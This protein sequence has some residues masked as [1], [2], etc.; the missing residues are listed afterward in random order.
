MSAKMKNN[1][2]LDQNTLS[3]GI[4]FGSTRV[5]AVLI[6]DT[7]APIASGAYDWENKLVE[8]YWTYSLD[9]VWSGLQHAFSELSQNVKNDYDVILTN[10]G[11]IGFSGMMHGY[12]AF[13]KDE[14]LLVPFRTWRNTT[15]DVASKKLTELFEFNI[16]HRWSIAHLY[17]AVLNKEEHVQQIDYVTTLAGFVHWKLT[18]QK[19]IGVGEAA[20]MF[21]IDSHTVDYDRKRIEEFEA[22]SDVQEYDW[23]LS[24]VLPEVLTAGS[25]AGVLSEEG[26]RLLD[27]SGQLMPGIP[28]CPPEGDAGTG[29]VA[30]N[31]VAE[32][33]GNVSAGTSVFS[34]IVLEEALSSYYEEID[35]VTTPTGKPTAMV[36]CNNFTT[37]IN[38]W[39]KLFGELVEVL[40]LNVDKDQL[41]TTLFEKSLE[42]DADG[43]KL[44]S[45]NYYSGEP[46]TGLEEGRPLFVQMPDSVLSLPNFMRTQIYSALATL[47]IGMDILIAKENVQVDQLLGHGGFFRTKY[48]GQKMMADALKVPVSVMET[49]G[50]GGPWGMALLASYLINKEA[51]QSMESFLN[52]QVFSIESPNSVEPS[53]TG[54][55][56]FEEFMERYTMMLE[57]EKTAVKSI[58]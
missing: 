32:R 25:V 15:T 37:D 14:Q 58:T 51:G 34:M 54:S 55:N 24:Q 18:G 23:K 42:A 2:T 35:M 20:G 36:H 17:Q 38:A 16:P 11:S 29:M 31:A 27:P 57:V 8:G 56:D 19:V 6:D 43:G 46:I 28:L 49:A 12:L 52:N 22:L 21:P 7:F 48:V 5:K 13:D 3:L 4:E 40:G 30:T 53:V 50:E 10:I 47:K 39:A 1:L 45:C 33:T 9:E 44:M 41:F 26:A